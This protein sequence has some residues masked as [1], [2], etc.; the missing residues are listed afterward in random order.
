MFL[1]MIS[2]GFR[3]PGASSSTPGD[4][5]SPSQPEAFQDGA[6]E[7]IEYPEHSAEITFGKATDEDDVLSTPDTPAEHSEVPPS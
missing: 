5:A 7:V 3:E 2:P 4:N 1:K 6:T